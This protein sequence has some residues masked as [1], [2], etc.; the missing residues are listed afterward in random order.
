MDEIP[1]RPQ[2]TSST[3][4]RLAWGRS[5]SPL[6]TSGKLSEVRTISL[7]SRMTRCRIRPETEFFPLASPTMS[8]QGIS[9][10]SHA[11]AFSF[12]FQLSDFILPS[13]LGV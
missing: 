6:F 3:A 10:H 13:E 12:K 5:R 2:R 11:R 1:Q 8:P 4:A 7:R 9:V